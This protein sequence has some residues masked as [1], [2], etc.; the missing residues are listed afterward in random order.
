MVKPKFS[1]STTYQF[2]FTNSTGNTATMVNKETERMTCSILY[3]MF[4]RTAPVSG[5]VCGYGFFNDTS[6]IPYGI[7][8]ESKHPAQTPMCFRGP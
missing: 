3:P 1:I 2:Y 4:D 6:P 7:P 8:S 5:L